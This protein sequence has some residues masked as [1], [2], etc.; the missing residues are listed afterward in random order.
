MEFVEGIGTKSLPEEEFQRIR[1]LNL[2]KGL[3]DILG[4]ILKAR[5]QGLQDMFP[6]G[7]Q[8]PLLQSLPQSLLY[9]LV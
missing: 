4:N 7:L 1:I 2:P 9:S 3:K 8:R 6:C 5:I